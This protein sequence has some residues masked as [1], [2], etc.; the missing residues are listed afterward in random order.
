MNAWCTDIVIPEKIWITAHVQ[1]YFFY[2]TDC[3]LCVYVCIGSVHL[4]LAST[5]FWP[6]ADRI[7]PKD[8]A[9]Q[10]TL[11]EPC[12]STA[13]GKN[14]CV[15]NERSLPCV[16]LPPGG[17]NKSTGSTPSRGPSAYA[18]PTC[19]QSGSWHR[20]ARSARG[21]RRCAPSSPPRLGPAAHGTACA[22][23]AFFGFCSGSRW[24]HL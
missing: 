14:G 4:V 18:R 2:S 7:F 16:F 22:S 10:L 19:V 9:P 17:S 12:Q 8:T 3:G 5:W 24:F 21:P 20:A 23:P 1:T 13:R 6:G 11:C 15:T